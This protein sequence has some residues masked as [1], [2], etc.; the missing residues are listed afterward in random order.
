MGRCTLKSCVSRLCTGDPVVDIEV[1][2]RRP[3]VTPEQMIDRRKTLHSLFAGVSQDQAV[4][5]LSLLFTSGRPDRACPGTFAYSIAHLRLE[6][7]SRTAKLG[8]AIHA[9]RR[10]GAP[11]RSRNTQIGF[12]EALVAACELA[13]FAVAI[14]G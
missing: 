14:R 1:Q 9:E 2:L 11:R 12:N 5:L 6:L 4:G 8:P 3:V 7:L 10:Q 13:V